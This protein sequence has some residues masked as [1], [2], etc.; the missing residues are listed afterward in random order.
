MLFMYI[1]WVLTGVWWPAVAL[2]LIVLVMCLVY[3]NTFYE[4]LPEGLLLSCGLLSKAIPY[5]AIIS[6]TD[7]DSISPSYCLASKRVMIRYVEGE[8]IKHTYASP[9]NRPQFR[10]LLNKAMAKYALETKGAEKTELDIAVSKAKKEQIPQTKAEE[11]AAAELEKQLKAETE[12]VAMEKP[13]MKER[14]SKIVSKNDNKILSR[15]EQ[16]KMKEEK[17]LLER[18]RK[19]KEKETKEAQKQE[20]LIK[21]RQIRA[22]QEQNVMTTKKKQAELKKQNAEMKEKTLNQKLES[23]QKKLVAKET[24]K[25]HKLEAKRVAKDKKLA[26]ANKAMAEKEAKRTSKKKVEK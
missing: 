8:E 7:A 10:E 16:K 17:K 9:A 21:E 23:Q 4:L 25:A 2:T 14:V 24:A 15:E 18:L 3:F 1:A 26:A 13:K 6:V 22:M 5:R 11:R 12:T 20:E 19:Q